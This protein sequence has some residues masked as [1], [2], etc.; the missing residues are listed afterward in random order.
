MNKSLRLQK[1]NQ[2]IWIITI[3]LLLCAIHLCAIRSVPHLLRDGPDFS[4]EPPPSKNASLYLNVTRSIDGILYMAYYFP[5]YHVAPENRLQTTDIKTLYT[6]WDVLRAHEHSLTPH[7]F[8]DLSDHKVM[9]HHD[10]LAFKYKVGVFIFYHFW[11]DNSMVLNLPVDIFIRERRKTK[12]VLCWDNESGFLGKQM[13]DKP[14][15]HAYQL[16]RYFMSENYLT[17]DD[18]RK[19]FIIYHTRE[20]KGHEWYLEKIITFLLTYGVR[21]K[22]AHC[23]MEHKNRWDLPIWSEVAVEF[24]PHLKGGAKR[25]NLYEYDRRDPQSGSV[26]EYWQGITSSWDSRPRCASTRT[27]QTSCGGLR[28]NGM[29]SPKGFGRLVRQVKDAIHPLNVQKIVTVF[30]WNEWAEGAAL[31]P[32]KEYNV[33][34]L[35]QLS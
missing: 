18:N 6:D 23:Y 10:N 19:P 11:L 12:F 22:L 20:M 8:Y 4:F 17:D 24:G 27:H 7:H 15:K 13:Y 2:L 14:E 35:E 33:S 25:K 9:M 31:E 28:P 34:F 16:L 21:L 29:V 30:A 26:A 5:Q 32:S 3:S 1:K